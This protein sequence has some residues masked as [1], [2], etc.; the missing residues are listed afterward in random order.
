MTAENSMVERCAR[1]AMADI[2]RQLDGKPIPDA[3]DVLNSWSASGQSI[4]MEE[5]A[6][7]VIEAMREPTR[8]MVRLADEQFDWGPSGYDDAPLGPAAPAPVFRSMISAA[9]QTE[10]GKD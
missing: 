9:L 5:V 3:P 10:K 4:N 8:E 7:A 1:A 2:K 6:R